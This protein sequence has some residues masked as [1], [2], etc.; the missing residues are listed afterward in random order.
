MTLGIPNYPMNDEAHAII[1]L[2][3]ETAEDIELWP[4]LM[5][6][7]NDGWRDGEEDNAYW[8]HL[9]RAQ[10]LNKTLGHMH[11]KVGVANN[12]L[13]FLP[14]AIFTVD[15][16][17]Q[18]HN[19]NSLAYKF[20]ETSRLISLEQGQLIQKDKT[21]EGALRSI[22]KNAFN[23]ASQ[24]HCVAR[25]FDSSSQETLSVYAVVTENGDD[26]PNKKMCNLFVASKL[27]PR[28]VNAS[29][30]RE[31]YG[32]TPAEVRVAQNL[33]SGSALTD[34]ADT[35][36][37]THNT[38]RNQLKSIFSKT[39]T[40][41]QTELVGL[42]LSTPTNVIKDSLKTISPAKNNGS[43]ENTPQLQSLELANGYRMAFYEVGDS[44]GT[45]IVYMHEFVA[46]DWW[47]LVG[48]AVLKEN[49]IRLIVPLRPG[50][51][52]SENMKS[53]S[54]E[55]WCNHLREFLVSREVEKFYIL[56]FSTGSPFAVS[57]AH[58]LSAMCLGLTLVNGSAPLH[59]ISEMETAKPSMSRLVLG[60]AKY[61][62]KIYQK[63]FQALV[64]TIKANPESY[65]RNYMKHWSEFDS[66]LVADSAV[67]DSLI[68]RFDECISTGAKGLILEPVIFTQDWGFSLEDISVPTK[69]WQGK[70]DCAFPQS[71][72]GRLQSIPESETVVL[73]GVGHMMM[74][75]YW[76][77]I[78]QSMVSGESAIDDLEGGRLGAWV[79]FTI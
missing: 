14:M 58:Y 16:N 19:A 64:K 46:W 74:S 37:V 57:A 8:A 18:L 2:I 29:V 66:R 10:Q 28:Y 21:N 4:K 12:A 26:A 47:N 17:L 75:T 67:L 48:G 13:D 33:V 72:R 61:M 71:M 27:L 55:L 36:G 23:Q 73:P 1:S 35:L 38:V 42:I 68:A 65:I 59:S 70:D 5:E 50:Y 32:L 51:F 7:F 30:L 22:V 62:P 25:L 41:R 39:D 78:I 60:F 34:I 52:G 56:G 53:D 9:D 31:T 76:R 40:K 3:Y 79:N 44:Q 63:F 15:E 45:P 49:N 20:V 6:A 43:E 11:E 69:L 77:E 24:A 54:L